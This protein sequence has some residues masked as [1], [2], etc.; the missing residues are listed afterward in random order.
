MQLT[1]DGI[2]PIS[3]APVQASRGHFPD[4]AAPPANVPSVVRTSDGDVGPRCASSAA[5][6]HPSCQPGSSHRCPAGHCL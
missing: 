4:S 5:P 2:R 1:C 6:T 3:V